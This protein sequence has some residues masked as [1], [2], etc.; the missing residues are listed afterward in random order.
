[1]PP[2]R[3]FEY[4]QAA[5]FNPTISPADLGAGNLDVGAGNYSIKKFNPDALKAWAKSS[6]IGETEDLGAYSEI[7][8]KNS[9]LYVMA[10]YGVESIRGNFGVRYV[11][12]DATSTYYLAGNKQDAEADYAEFLP[13]FNIVMD[14]ADDVILRASAARTLARPQYV[15]MYV[16]PNVMGTNDDLPNNQ[17]W[18]VGNIALKP[19]IADQFDLGIEWYFDANSMVSAGLFTKDV[20]N[21]VNVT[22]STA[23]AD[24]IPFPLTR[25]EEAANG[26]IVQQKEN[27]KDATIQGL[28]LQYQQYFGNGFGSLVNYTYTDTETDPTTF[29]DLNGIL[30]DSSR[31]SYNLSGYYE[32]EMFQVR[33][34]YNWRSEYMIR[35]AGSYGN[36]LHDDYGS[37][38][39][40]SVWHVTDNVDIKLDVVNLLE[41]GSKQ[42]GNNQGKS[43]YSGFADGFPVFEY[44][45]ARR[46][47]LGASF[48][49]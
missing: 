21:F 2:A 18:V 4:I 8:E 13:S 9:A 15:D 36:R 22:D 12:T 17:R 37:L 14:L 25:P 26:W 38:D 49:F 45:M 44:E 31:P 46:I 11:S 28:E 47:S 24:E 3:R 39:L 41:E 30:S 20:K 40:S 1:M 34:S 32:D 7:D 48:R 33:V 27:G 35:E 16:N 19:F 10:N 23:T 6:I 5:G 29:S 43:F 42:F